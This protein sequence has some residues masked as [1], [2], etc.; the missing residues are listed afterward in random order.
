[1]MQTPNI[2]KIGRLALFLLTVA[3]SL[4]AAAQTNGSNSPYSRYGL[5][6]LHDGAQSFNKGMSG[7]GYALKDGEQLNFKNP[8]TYAAID[9]AAF[10][11]DIGFTLQN[12]NIGTKGNRVNARNARVD[13]AAVGFRMLPGF[14]LSLGLRPYSTIG[15]NLSGTSTFERAG[16]D[17][18]QTETY[19]GDGGLREVYMGLGYSPFKGL[20]VGFNFGYLWGELDHSVM[21]SFSDN[22]IYSRNR[23][24]KANITTYKAEFGMQ[25][26]ARL[27]P[28]SSG[29]I[30]LVYGLGH[31]IS[32]RANYYDQQISSST[33]ITADTQRVKKAFAL[34]HTFGVGLGWNYNDKLKV[35]LDYTLQK[36]GSVKCPTLDGNT[37]VTREGDLKDR[38][39]FA[40]GAEYMPNPRSTYWRH[41]VRY[42]AGL[43]YSTPYIRVN[44]EDG[45]SEYGAS[46]G[47]SMPIT[48]RYNYMGNYPLLHLSAG[49]RRVE[50]KHSWQVAENYMWFSVGFTFNELWFQKWRVR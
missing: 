44:G 6:L 49:F 28:K 27:S 21:A 24:Y 19:D 48:T 7:V 23:S 11:F 10:L 5:G 22:T 42:R 20:S 29:S 32:S 37:Y 13:Y 40:L 45:P 16:V 12:A 35:G 31:D 34:P 41:H 43:T 15:Y 30:G 50:P 9:S 33:V 3:L 4:P 2:R 36:W 47:V 26:H 1:M 14:G 38:H 25:Y 46:I 18:T 17:V 8:A 39:T